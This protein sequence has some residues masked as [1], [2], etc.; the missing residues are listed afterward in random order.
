VTSCQAYSNGSLSA[1][2]GNGFKMGSSGMNL[3]HVMTSD[4]AHNNSGTTGCGFTQNGN[5]G[6]TKIISC[7]SYSNKNKDVL[8]NCVLSGGSTMQL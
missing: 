4:V 6:A 1:G 5:T 8:T 2:N 7:N 3:A